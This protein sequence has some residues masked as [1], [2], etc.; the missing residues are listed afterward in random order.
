MKGC[1]MGG[2]FA[3]SGVGNPDWK[4]AED[5]TMG[6]E[7][8]CTCDWAGTVAEVKALLENGELILRGEIRRRVA[9]SE[10]K[11]VRVQSDCL[12][13]MVGGEPVELVLGDLVAAKWAATIT[14][15]PVSLA[16]KLGIT[17]KTVVRT[18]GSIGDENLKAALADAAR[19]TSSDADLIVACVDSPESLRAALDLVESDLRKGVPIWLVYAK[20]LGRA[21]NETAIRPLLRASGLMDTKVA[22]V[23]STLTAMRF[24]CAKRIEAHP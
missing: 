8:V 3:H 13:F 20:G 15:P 1:P 14:S 4:R 9:F 2:P 11:G 22:S 17:D 19:V 7:A 16:R 5:R 18:I 10:I 12:C 24:N 6:R 21:L 23:S